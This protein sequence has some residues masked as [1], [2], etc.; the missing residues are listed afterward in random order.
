MTDEQKT[1]VEAPVEPVDDADIVTDPVVAEENAHEKLVSNVA[2]MLHEEKEETPDEPSEKPG[3][4]PEDT[5]EGE[6]EF[7]S[8]LRTRAKES[9]LSEDLA[10]RLHQAGQLEETIAA[11][12]R[13]MIEQVQAKTVKDEP[14]KPEPKA[15]VKEEPQT[16]DSDVPALDP[17]VYDEQLVKRD[18]Y[19][20]KRIDQLESQLQ[21][22]LQERQRGLDTWFDSVLSELGVDTNDDE[23][24]QTVFSAYGAIC[25]AMGTDPT[26]C[27]KKMAER[28]YAAMYPQ[29]VIKAN[30]RQTLDRLRDAQGRFLSK[31]KSRGGPPPKDVSDE[32]VH[33]QLISDV[34]AYLKEQGVQMSGL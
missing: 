34:T 23:K 19:Q 13:R 22:L 11:F 20:T 2:K 33:G 26:S 8:E 30:Q 7:S 6:V 16:D 3:D 14:V 17:E 1:E 31:T 12:D 10:E 21:S 5:A 24:C 29:E 9:G 27:N 28:A 25:E 4:E 15:E 32:E 18:A